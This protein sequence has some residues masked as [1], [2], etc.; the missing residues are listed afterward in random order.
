MT[1]SRRMVS[2]SGIR[3]SLLR[4]KS[5]MAGVGVPGPTVMLGVSATPQQTGSTS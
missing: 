4:T 3:V 1:I 2:W 5:M